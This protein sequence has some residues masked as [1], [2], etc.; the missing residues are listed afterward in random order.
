MGHFCPDT[1]KVIWS[2]NSK[3]F[4]LRLAHYLMNS[5]DSCNYLSKWDCKKL[6]VPKQ[7]NLLNARIVNIDSIDLAK[8]RLC[9]LPYFLSTKKKC[10][11]PFGAIAFIIF[12]FFFLLYLIF[13]F[14][15]FLSPLSLCSQ[16][17][18]AAESIEQQQWL[19]GIWS[20]L[21]RLKL[22]EK[23]A[24]VWLPWKA[25]VWRSTCLNK[26][27]VWQSDFLMVWRDLMACLYHLF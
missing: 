13:F 20:C 16:F 3:H 26:L 24:Y 21:E 1:W 8:M 12:F 22:I 7:S 25:V 15:F 5:A 6:V 10:H 9:Y 14:F 11:F 18:F 23:L 17:C 27:R 19:P 4:S 2:R